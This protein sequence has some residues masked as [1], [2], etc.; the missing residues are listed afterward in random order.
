M[1][2]EQRFYEI[3]RNLNAK[4]P[5]GQPRYK[6]PYSDTTIYMAKLTKHLNKQ[7]SY[8]KCGEEQTYT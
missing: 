4:P 2:S 8:S 6:Y 5:H 7:P 1:K 3:P